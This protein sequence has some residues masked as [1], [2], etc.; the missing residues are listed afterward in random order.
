[1]YN[2][3]EKPWLGRNARISACAWDK[4]TP[5]P[6]QRQ[7]SHTFSA[8]VWGKAWFRKRLPHKQ[9]DPYSVLRNNREK[10]KHWVH[11]CDRGRCCSV[12][13]GHPA[14]LTWQILGQ[15]GDC[16]RKKKRRRR[17]RRR[18]KKSE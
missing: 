3:E 4:A 16:L 12:A 6:S 14:H 13:S 8:K 17:R 15:V 10:V 18:R 1:M 5:T 7:S 9:Q 11:A 2:P